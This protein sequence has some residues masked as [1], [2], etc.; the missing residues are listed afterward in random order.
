MTAQPSPAAGAP[1][2]PGLRGALASLL[3]LL[4]GVLLVAA[5]LGASAASADEPV[6]RTLS[7]ETVSVE[8]PR[9]PR[10]IRARTAIVIDAGNGVQL[11]GRS[12][13]RRTLI[14]S[15]TKIMTAL[16]A[17]DRTQPEEV[18]V[19]SGY[20]GGA[21]ES[22]LG[23]KPGERMT[24][25][26]LILGLML[27]SGNDAADTLA[28]RTAGTR[29]RF[30]ADMNRRARHM[31]LPNTRFANAIGLDDRNNYS[32]A[33]DLAQLA[34][35]ALRVPR[36]A[37]VVKRPAATLQSGERVRRIVNRNPLVARH[38]WVNGVKTGH[39]MA[40]GY[41]L[42]ASATKHDADVISV[43]TGE[44]SEAARED[45]ST[46]LLR[47]GRAHFASVEPVAT[48]KPLAALP[49]D[50]QDIAAHLVARESVKLA[51]RDGQAVTVRLTAP[52]SI[53][54][55]RSKGE[56]VGEAVVLRDG[57]QLARVP[58]ALAESIPKAPVT[59]VMLHHLEL[60]LPWL[61]LLIALLLL[62][63][64]FVRRSKSRTGR[65][66]FVG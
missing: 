49:V 64:Y 55:P 33:S 15:T 27:E 1:K 36:F 59:A 50:Y 32:S 7:D 9:A 35:A 5:L 11:W 41:L 14:A 62:A 2:V 61:L 42:V 60:V 56:V 58:V 13:N 39:T 51:A 10:G 34:R 29:A 31:G 66:R 17:I 37:S 48:R 25:Q 53:R 20:Q 52:R 16:V 38:R 23:L 18:L 8:P 65:P 12:A 57:E 44:P 54:G 43:V 40:A 24:A 22:L 26:D 63:T 30:V 4:L 3:C 21:G 19:S 28:L 47:F 46:A 6:V 45:D